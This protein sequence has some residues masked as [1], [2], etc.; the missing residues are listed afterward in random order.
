[1]IFFIKNDVSLSRK[2][3]RS[4]Q[5]LNIEL[6]TFKDLTTKCLWP[7]CIIMQ[8]YIHIVQR[9]I[10]TTSLVILIIFHQVIEGVN[11]LPTSFSLFL[12]SSTV[13]ANLTCRTPGIELVPSMIS[14][15][16]LVVLK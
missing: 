4:N 3:I 11:A 6:Y 9:K 2:A 12:T 8:D 13:S 5:V 14:C 10:T 7:M 16:S 1:M 15:I